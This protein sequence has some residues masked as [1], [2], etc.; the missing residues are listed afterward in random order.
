MFLVS[1]A[2]GA[3]QLFPWD[4]PKVG[5]FGERSDFSVLDWRQA[6][7][8]LEAGW[9][10]G[11][12]TRTHRRLKGMGRDEAWAE[13]SGSR[14]ALEER[15]GMP[16]NTFSYPEGSLDE[17]VVELVRLAGYELAV[18][19]ARTGRE[20]H[21]PLTVRRVGLYQSNDRMAFR[22]KTSRPFRRGYDLLQRLRER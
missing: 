20:P 13:V 7:D 17:D 18:V 4:E 11:S 10:L 3:G 12:H 1:E 15:L 22:M 2:V 6:S 8:L 21:S 16:I 14:S 5:T 9:E 19:T